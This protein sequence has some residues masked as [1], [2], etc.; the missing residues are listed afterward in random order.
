MTEWLFDTLVWTAVLIALVLLVRRPVARW[1]GP[2]VAYA[3]WALPMIRLLLPPIQ[4]PSWLAPAATPD[5]SNSTLLILDPATSFATQEAV[6]GQSSGS[7]A[8]ASGAAMPITPQ[9]LLETVLD[10]GPW[11]ELGLVVWLTGAAIFLCLR[12]SA[13]FR[14]RGELLE[15]AR[16]VG[17]MD[18]VRLI[19]TPGTTSP[20]AFGVSDKV[21]ALPSRFMAQSDRAAR[22]LAL[23]HELAHHTGRDLLI[24]MIVQPLFALHWFNPLGRYGWLAL[25]RDQEAACDAR[26]I[27]TKPSET[28]ALYANVI[29]GFATGPKVALAAPM[30]CPV[31]GEKSIIQRLRSL[32]MSDHS[33]RRIITGRFLMGA[34]VLALPLTASISYAEAEVPTAP[35]A[36]MVAAG[37]PSAPAAPKAPAAPLF[38]EVIESI[39][40]DTAMG[41]DEKTVREVIVITGDEEDGVSTKTSKQT[42]KI[43]DRGAKMSEEERKAM[44]RELREGLKEAD[45]ALKDV[46]G[47]VEEA[48]MEIDT[49]GAGRTVVKMECRGGKGDIAKVEELKDGGR[50]VYLCQTRVMAEA[51][52]GLKEAR[53]AIAE[54]R[55][56]T[57]EMRSEVLEVI[58]E[59]I[60]TWKKSE[61]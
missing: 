60:K 33:P 32:T 2:Q 58:D 57:G 47:I 30:A 43:V 24:N 21:I 22:N 4:L 45:K 20:I 51:L 50:N 35:E 9:P 25:R 26:V 54:N 48:M 56:I 12:F 39:D 31:L 59:Q 44:I 10:S 14:L 1:F 38:Q 23:D 15:G 61:G 37:V 13:Y 52:K 17:R 5:S 19:E 18:A 11:L 29:A 7:E 53:K 27:A 16:E 42:I 40:P 49:A 55:E 34:G 8:A 28:R 3:L 46:P 41:S 6:A 36:P